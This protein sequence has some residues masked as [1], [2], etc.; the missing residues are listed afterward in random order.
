MRIVINCNP[1]DVRKDALDKAVEYALNRG[2]D[3]SCVGI[4]VNAPDRVG[5]QETI[6]VMESDPEGSWIRGKSMVIGQI[7]RAPGA[8][9]EYHS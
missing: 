2:R 4:H 1:D 7:Q 8:P 5:F 6:I 9:L 3:N